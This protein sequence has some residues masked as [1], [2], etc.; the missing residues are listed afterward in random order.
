MFGR[1][2]KLSTLPIDDARSWTLS[3]ICVREQQFQ[4]MGSSRRAGKIVDHHHHTVI[5]HKHTAQA[6]AAAAEAFDW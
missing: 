5:Q 2:C 3:D 4:W 1:N 6:A